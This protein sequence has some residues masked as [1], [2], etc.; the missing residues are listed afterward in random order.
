MNRYAIMRHAKIKAGRH[1]VSTGLHLTRGADTPNADSAAMPIEILVGTN[2]PHK[3][4]MRALCKRGVL[5]RKLKKD[6]NAAVEVFLGASPDWWAAHGWTPGTHATGA[7][8]EIM[9]EWKM[10][11]IDYLRERFGDR[12]VSAQFHP[13]EANPHVQAL[14]IPVYWGKDG[15]ETGEHAGR[16]TWRLSTEKLLKGPRHLKQLQTEYAK[17]MAHFGLVRGEDDPAP[18]LGKDA[19]RARTH[20]G[21]NPR[22]CGEV[23]ERI[24]HRAPGD[25]IEGAD[26]RS[27]RRTDGRR[28]A[29]RHAPRSRRREGMMQQQNYHPSLPIDEAEAVVRREGGYVHL[30]YLKDARNGFIRYTREAGGRVLLQAFHRSWI[31]ALFNRRP[32]TS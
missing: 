12:L 4:V 14:V 9:T 24:D 30:V 29:R 2:K 16:E 11:Q 22:L 32:F 6:A 5:E 7:L 27:S 17:A 21:T 3:D 1:L 20:D 10:A 15:R 28:H 25:R 18:A 26:R 19:E 23:A 31:D 13:D 8:L